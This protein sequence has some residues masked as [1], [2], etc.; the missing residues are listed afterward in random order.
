MLCLQLDGSAI[1]G[2]FV[3]GRNSVRKNRTAEAC[4]REVESVSDHR[5]G[6]ADATEGFWGIR[7]FDFERWEGEEEKG[8]VLGF[9]RFRGAKI[10]W[11]GESG[12]VEQWCDVN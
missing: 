6:R 10:R 8:A 12:R 5:G 2:S 7:G 3:A 1:R 11:A 4:T 9:S